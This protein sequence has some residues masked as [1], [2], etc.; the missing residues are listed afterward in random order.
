MAQQSGYV[1]KATGESYDGL[2]LEY[3]GRLVTTQTG[4]YEGY[5]SKTLTIGSAATNGNTSPP[6]PIN[7]GGTNGG[8]G[9]IVI[10]DPGL[11]NQQQNQ[12]GGGGY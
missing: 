2:I 7:G 11:D 3:G 12:G 6:P 1:I 5:F 4:T 9:G 10:D 8:N